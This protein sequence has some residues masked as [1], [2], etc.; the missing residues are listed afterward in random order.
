MMRTPHEMIFAS[1]GTGK[2]FA[3]TNRVIRLLL[4]DTAPERILALTFSRAA[5]GE[6]FDTVTG[7]LAEAAGDPA[8]AVA[9]GGHAGVKGLDSERCREAL[10]RLLDRM[11]L[12]PIGTLDSFF[13]RMLQA[14]PF[15]LGGG[16]EFAIL[17]PAVLEAEKGRL[18]RGLLQPAANRREV[19]EQQDLFEA[20]KRATFGREEKQLETRLRQFAASCHELSLDISAEAWAAE[21]RIWPAGSPWP[22]LTPDGAR[23]AAAAVI[24]PG[25]TPAQAERLAAFLAAAA[26]FRPGSVL[27]R[28]GEA[29]KAFE[30]FLEALPDLETG[31]ADIGLNRGKLTAVG[32][33]AAALERLVRHVAGSL[34]EAQVE[35]TRG[36]RELMARYEAAYHERLRLGGKLT[37]GDVQRLLAGHAE[38]FSGDLRMIM[39]YRLDA[40][41]DHWLLDEFQDTSRL[42]WEILRNLADELLQ[43][44]SG[45]RSLFVVGDVKQAIYGWRGGDSALMAEILEYYNSAGEERIAVGSLTETQRCRPP[46]VDAVNA[47]FGHLAGTLP[48][49]VRDRWS[50][51]CRW[52]TH[53]SAKPKEA[54]LARFVELPYVKG[55]KAD[56]ARGRRWAAVAARLAEVR[57]WERRGPDGA[58]PTAAV[59]V[60]NNTAGRELVDHLRRL[61]IPAA[62]N[63]DAEILDNPVLALVESLLRVAA[64]PGDTLAW[65]HLRMTPLEPWLQ[66]TGATPGSVSLELLR[67]L[68]ERGFEAALDIWLGRLREGWPE[69]DLFSLRRISE[70]LEAAQ[71]FDRGGLSKDPL[72]FLELLAARKVAE[73]PVPGTVQVMTLHKSKGLGFDWVFLPDL[74]AQSGGALGAITFLH[75]GRPGAADEWLLARPPKMLVEADKALAAAAEEAADAG[76]FEE[77]CLLYVGMTRAKRELMLVATARSPESKAESVTLAQVVKPGMLAEGWTRFGVT[78]YEAGEVFCE[79]GEPDWFA[80]VFPTVASGA[81]AAPE[82]GGGEPVVLPVA[83][84]MP[85]PRRRHPRL[86]PSRGAGEGA[87]LRAGFLFDRDAGFNRGREV[88]VLCHE[89]LRR[90][91]WLAADG[92]G[93]EPELVTWRR[94]CPAVAAVR[95]EAAGLLQKALAEP[96]VREAFAQPSPQAEVWRERGFEAIL[97]GRWVS[98]VF[99]RVVLD[100]DAAGNLRA[101]VVWDFKSED[102]DGTGKDIVAARLARHRPQLAMYRQALAKLTGLP[103]NAVS[104][105]LLFLRGPLVAGEHEA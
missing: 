40:A 62:W 19:A 36:I 100:R 70:L 49:T 17:D 73:P 8:R 31:H 102:L 10:R 33:V 95:D 6:I 97:D 57:P 14:F 43:D 26:E 44:T 103:E 55:E 27:E 69:P 22:R 41:F 7:R 64:H 48:E 84:P 92:S 77:L 85:G 87:G 11:H 24:F 3:L 60:R 89:F 63:G 66:R 79:F 61:D 65:E 75:H 16:G 58:A 59:L 39:E 38:A 45:T 34:L 42:Q 71:L 35:T 29:E 13:I 9:L 94:D 83:G 54:G 23:A 47:V 96:T 37:F 72:D 53:R 2:T 68:H 105:R 12:C 32:P 91:E 90:L 101:A 86:L 82:L 28:G 93:W 20:F 98:G 74:Q 50:G 88:G 52:A 21:D 80:P 30:K 4:E 99:D 104:V 56:A 76:Q 18:L 46:V 78:V 51:D 81:A 25:A 15:E 5:A 1:A 67:D